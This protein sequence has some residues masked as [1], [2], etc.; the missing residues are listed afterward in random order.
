MLAADPIYKYLKTKQ[1]GVMFSDIK[2]NF[3]KFLVDRDGNVVKRWDIS[4]AFALAQAPGRPG[5]GLCRRTLQH[6][7]CLWRCSRDQSS[8]LSFVLSY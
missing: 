7:M 2:W 5:A 8:A 4:P 6:M 3:S 1:G